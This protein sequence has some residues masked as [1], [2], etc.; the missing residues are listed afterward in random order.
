MTIT[1]GERHSGLILRLSRYRREDPG[2]RD[3]YPEFLPYAGHSMPSLCPPD[4]IEAETMEVDLPEY[5]FRR[6]M[7]AKDPLA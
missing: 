1:L 5:D 2:V 7:T 4:E 3:G 6:I